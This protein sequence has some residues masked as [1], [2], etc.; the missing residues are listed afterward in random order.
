ML[1]FD[2]F[3]SGTDPSIHDTT[4]VVDVILQHGIVGAM[5]L[6]VLYAYWRKDIALQTESAARIADAKLYG[7]A[8][9]NSREKLGT[10]MEK[11][12]DSSDGLMQEIKE[13]QRED[14]TSQIARPPTGQA[15]KR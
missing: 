7:E 3:D 8:M 13:R 6:I 9:A 5:L 10:M 15:F 4:G 14:R 12:N 1:L 2:L 11:F